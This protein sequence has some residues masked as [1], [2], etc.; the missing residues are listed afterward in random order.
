MEH[1]DRAWHIASELSADELIEIY[2]INNADS[3]KIEEI[4]YAIVV[5]IAELLES[6]GEVGSHLRKFLQDNWQ[7]VKAVDRAHGFGG[8]FDDYIIPF[9]GVS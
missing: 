1:Q 6:G 2:S 3:E 8:D 5:N 4:L 9:V 7:N